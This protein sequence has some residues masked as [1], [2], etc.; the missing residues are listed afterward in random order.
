MEEKYFLTHANIIYKNRFS[1]LLPSIKNK[2]M[3]FH[4]L[5]EWNLRAS[6]KQYG[7]KTNERTKNLFFSI[8]VRVPSEV[9]F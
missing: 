2:T 1:I 4:F 9:K 7:K 8:Y 6:D 5:V 3:N